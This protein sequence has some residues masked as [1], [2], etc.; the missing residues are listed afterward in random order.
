M[1]LIAPNVQ[2]YS[3]PDLRWRL[4]FQL[5][6]TPSDHWRSHLTLK[7]LY[8]PYWIRTMRDLCFLFHIQSS[9]RLPI[10]IISTSHHWVVGSYSDTLPTPLS[11]ILIKNLRT[12]TTA[13][14]SE[15]HAVHNPMGDG[16]N[17][18]RL[19]DGN[20]PARR[21]FNTAQADSSDSRVIASQDCCV[22]SA[23]SRFDFSV[24]LLARYIVYRY[25]HRFYCRCTS[26]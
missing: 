19:S 24:R 18:K 21:S 4:V 2:R 17:P 25:R 3:T 14:W 22:S 23:T 16:R 15:I 13:I 9:I 8:H 1:K 6:R 26:I 10:L 7:H 12:C 20:L 11:R 5:Y